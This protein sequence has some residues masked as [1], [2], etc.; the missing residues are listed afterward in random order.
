MSNFQIL[1][2]ELD[3]LPP[4][5]MDSANA[6]EERTVARNFLEY[7]VLFSIDKGDKDAFQKHLSGLRPFYTNFSAGLPVS[8]MMHTILGLNL[9]HLLVENR[10][11][12]F[13]CELELLTEVQSSNPAIAFCT[14][15]DQHLMVGSYDQVLASASNPPVDRYAFFLKSLLETVRINIGE[16]AAASYK[17]LSLKAAT[18]MLMFDSEKETHVF[19]SDFYPD[20]TINGSEVVLCEMKAPK[21][22]GIP[23][24]KLISQTLSYAAELERIV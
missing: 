15:L 13:H 21:S 3:S 5:G 17:M 14:Q 11:A 20:W 8:E 4:L 16:C 12:D 9:L 23:S 1:M 2:L 6:R 19:I 7:A 10:L 22:E 18:K 24:M